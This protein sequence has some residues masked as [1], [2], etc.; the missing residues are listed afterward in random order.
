M[1]RFD[2]RDR[3]STL[4][5]KRLLCP[6]KC[7]SGHVPVRAWSG[8]NDLL[9][10]NAV[11]VPLGSNVGRLHVTKHMHE[12]PQDCRR[13]HFRLRHGS[14]PCCL[15]R[16]TQTGVLG[17][18]GTRLEPFSPVLFDFSKGFQ[19]FAYGTAF[20]LKSIVTVLHASVKA[21]ATGSD[22]THVGRQGIIGVT[23][24]SGFGKGVRR[25]A[26]LGKSG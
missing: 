26:C 25:I 21:E 16:T 1:R 6:T 11:H 5:F 4:D 20:V 9:A 12:Y 13:G 17:R 23:W 22:L 2:A 10:Q 24:P 3:C 7:Q 15:Y 14:G 18:L 8:K 19:T